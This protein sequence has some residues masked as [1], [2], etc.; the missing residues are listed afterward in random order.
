MESAWVFVV[1]AP[2]RFVQKEQLKGNHHLLGGAQA[3]FFFFFLSWCPYCG[4]LRYPLQSHER[5]YR[6]PLSCEQGCGS[7]PCARGTSPFSSIFP[8]E[9]GHGHGLEAWQGCVLNVAIWVGFMGNEGETTQVWVDLFFPDLFLGVGLIRSR[10]T[11]SMLGDSNLNPPILRQSHVILA[12]SRG[13]RWSWFSCF[14]AKGAYRVA[15]FDSGWL[16]L[17]FLD[18]PMSFDSETLRSCPPRKGRY[19]TNVSQLCSLWAA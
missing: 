18:V 8:D 3:S 5:N 16:H 15:S 6:R 11:H 14:C 4:W 10:G 13:F 19:P 1:G 12:T 9:L 2:N 7:Q 17:K